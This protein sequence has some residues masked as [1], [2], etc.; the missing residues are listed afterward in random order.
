MSDFWKGLLSA[1]LEVAG[2]IFLKWIQ[3][4]QDESGKRQLGAIEYE[5]YVLKQQQ[6]RAKAADTVERMLGNASGDELA[7]RMRSTNAAYEAYTANNQ[8]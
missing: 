3:M 4:G 1:I 2:G 6:A 5:N 8:S 7:A